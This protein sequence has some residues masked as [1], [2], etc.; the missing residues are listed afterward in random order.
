MF[1]VYFHL[2]EVINHYFSFKK[3][4]PFYYQ[5]E[6]RG[7]FYLWT[8]LTPVILSISTT[9]VFA[10]NYYNMASYGS[11]LMIRAATAARNPT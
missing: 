9:G 1:K 5:H 10:V 7:R 2:K 11:M 6:I 4:H 8:A 3:L